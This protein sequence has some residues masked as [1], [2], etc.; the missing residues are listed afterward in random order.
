MAAPKNSAAPNPS[1]FDSPRAAPRCRSRILVEILVAGRVERG[2][3]AD[4]SPS[5][6]R[7]VG[8]VLSLAPGTPVEVRYLAAKGIAPKPLR[9]EFVRTTEDGFAIR[10][11]R[12]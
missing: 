9:G 3:I 4:V 11:L 10:I 2:A 7:I 8:P 6:A 12:D 5:G 1:G